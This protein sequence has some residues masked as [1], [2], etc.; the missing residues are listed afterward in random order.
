MDDARPIEPL[1]LDAEPGPID[2]EP[3]IG[4][5]EI[6]DLI[7]PAYQRTVTERAGRALIQRIA[8]EFSWRKFGALIVADRGGRYEVID[9]QHRA[10]A[11]A[12]RGDIKTVPA[13]VLP[14]GEGLPHDAGTF[15]SI[16]RDRRAVS[17]QATFWADVHRGEPDAVAAVEGAA[18][19]GA[20][21]LRAAKPAPSC[22]EGDVLAVGALRR[23]A[24]SKGKAGAARA[25]RV[26][27]GARFA[28]I[29]T[30]HLN[31]VRDLLWSSD[32]GGQASDAAIAE[33][34][35]TRW[36]E[37]MDEADLAKLDSGQSL[38][39]CLAVAVG[40]AARKRTAA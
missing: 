13:T 4:W 39:R 11:A 7:V 16:N 32:L 2:A 8:R 33:A 25:L 12:S 24:A 3:E 27:L 15:V 10:I 28:P 9:G 19:A 5:V 18:L 29:Q 31:V 14:S 34:M 35:R 38:G 36:D 6:S 21:I 37:L 26:C 20:T 22:A 23:I 1:A 17:A 40:K 30:L